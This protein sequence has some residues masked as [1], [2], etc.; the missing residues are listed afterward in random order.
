MASKAV[1]LDLGIQDEVWSHI[2][3]HN[4]QRKNKQTIRMKSEAASVGTMVRGNKSR[5]RAQGKKSR[6]R[7]HV[8]KNKK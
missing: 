2:S 1:A 8:K 5:H 7:A 3:G 4:G 6:H